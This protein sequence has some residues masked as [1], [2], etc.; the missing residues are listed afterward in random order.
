MRFIRHSSGIYVLMLVLA[1]AGLSGC[2]KSAPTQFFALAPMENPASTVPPCISLGVGPVETPVYLDRRSIMVRNGENKMT[3]SEFEEWA[4]PLKDGLAR[5]LAENLS[6]LVCAK[7]IAVYPWPV[8]VVPE[9]QVTVQVQRFDGAL[10]DKVELRATWAILDRN[11]EMVLWS[12]F[13]AEEPSGGDYASLAA[14]MS[15]LAG[16]L[17]K[18]IAEGLASVKQ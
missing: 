1:A 4:E 11:G 9:Y 10:R 13:T 6:G 17:S 2:G 8:G 12:S 15:R 16:G 14:A 5:T 7:P 3:L 18:D